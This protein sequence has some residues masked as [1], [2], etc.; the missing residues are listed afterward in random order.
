M[1][2]NLPA[3]WQEVLREALESPSFR[4]AGALRGAR[5]AQCHRAPFG[6][7][8]LLGVPADAVRPSPGA[9]AGAGPVPRAGAGARA[10]VLGAAGSAPPPSLVNIFKELRATWDCPGP[11]A[12]RWCR[13][14]AG[15]AAAQRGADGAPGRAQQPRGPGLGGVHRPVIRA[16]SAKPEPVVFLLWGNYARKKRK[17]ID[18]SGTW[19]SSRR[20]PRRCRPRG[21]SSAAARSAALMMRS[22][23]EGS[24]PSTGTGPGNGPNLR[25]CSP[26]GASLLG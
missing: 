26:R 9:A 7:G 5:A 8:A 13:G 23:S 22:C 21:A 25:R 11:A 24:R 3:D 14:R 16:V 15:R 4:E 1:R 19:S 18:A 10:G 6:G 2:E 17:L 20:T 12:A